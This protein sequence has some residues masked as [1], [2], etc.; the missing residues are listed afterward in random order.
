MTEVS[1]VTKA[2]MASFNVH[3]VRSSRFDQIGIGRD[4][5]LY[6]GAFP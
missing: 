5:Q 3:G 6:L 2:A 1:A 4:A